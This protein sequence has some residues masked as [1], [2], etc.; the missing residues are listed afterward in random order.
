MKPS[1]L[2]RDLFVCS[3][4]CP[5]HQFVVS[6]FKDEPELFFQVC[7]DRPG[8]LKR[9]WNALQY[10]FGK[11]CRYGFFDEVILYEEEVKRLHGVLERKL[12]ELKTL[13]KD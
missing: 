12:E 1:N 3:C 9:V 7:L 10:I 4:G 2:E 13:K 11:P 8:L 5:S 6:D